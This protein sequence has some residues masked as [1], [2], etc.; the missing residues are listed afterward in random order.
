MTIVRCT[1]VN[2]QSYRKL[3]KCEVSSVIFYYIDGCTER[4]GLATYLP[5][6][7][8]L[9]KAMQASLN[10]LQMKIGTDFAQNV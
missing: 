7:C 10:H 9:Y 5:D 2:K 8:M 3:L 1:L 6:T 4:K